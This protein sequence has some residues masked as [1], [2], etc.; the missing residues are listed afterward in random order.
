MLIVV[1]RKSQLALEY[2]Y[3]TRDESPQTFVFWVNASNAAMFEESYRRIAEEVKLPGRDDAMADILN[4]VGKWLRNVANARWIMI[5]DDADD[6]AF[7]DEL[8]KGKIVARAGIKPETIVGLDNFLPHNLNG[9]ILVTSRNVG[10]ALRLTGD[11]TRIIKVKSMDNSVAL[12]LLQKKVK[13]QFNRE[14]AKELLEA[15]GYLPLAI[16]Q[17]AAFINRNTPPLSISG[18]LNRFREAKQNLINRDSR[19]LL[20]SSS[21]AA[22]IG[23]S[24][25]RIY[26]A[27]PS[28]A[29]LLL[30]MSVFDHNEIPKSL[31]SYNKDQTNPHYPRNLDIEFEDNIS[32]LISYSLVGTNLE[33]NLFHM[34]ALVQLATREWIHPSVDM[35]KW[36][37]EGIRIMARAFPTGLYE[38]WATCRALY[39]HVKAVL[40]YRPKDRILILQWAEILLNAAWYAR[41]Q[42]SYGE[43]EDRKSVV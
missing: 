36:K 33:R 40:E 27:K 26:Q 23:L 15:L 17:A 14:D 24:L 11:A 39:P 22:T 43:A 21:M 20:Q 25:E 35:E 3:R 30:L 7:F 2:S 5:L 10:L 34:H 12:A 42:G 8:D 13:V 9:S 16:T 4:I 31:L 32:T 41:E 1:N 28:A 29:R 18:Y 37:E 6:S 19:H 38:N